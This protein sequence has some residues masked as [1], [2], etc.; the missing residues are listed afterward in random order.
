[1]LAMSNINKKRIIMKKHNIYSLFFYLV[2]FYM[3]CKALMNKDLFSE[4]VHQNSNKSEIKEKVLTQNEEHEFRDYEESASDLVRDFYRM[5]H[6][7]QTYDFVGSKI[8]EYC[9]LN[10]CV[11]SIWDAMKALDS[12]IDES[13]PDL[14]AAQS[15]HAFQTAEALRRDGHPRWFI[16]IG[17]IHDLGKVLVL[18]EEPQWA[19]VGDTFPVGCAYSEKVVYP[20]F[21]EYN[22]DI[23][24]Q[25]FQTLYGI[26]K[27]QCG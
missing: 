3:S 14:Q 24:N 10:H 17:L 15:L 7:Y 2:F 20:Q 18:F 5:N 16:L 23:H 22:P 21:F 1:M 8:D 27:P 25:K 26:Y 11:M 9:S 19:V 13:D 12:I 6:Q 4:R